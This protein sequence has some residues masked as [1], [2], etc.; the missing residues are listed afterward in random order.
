[1]KNQL[2]GKYLNVNFNNFRG[3]GLNVA[4]EESTNRSEE[5]NQF[6]KKTKKSLD[7]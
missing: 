1:M 2:K 7:G 6:Q 3:A 5:D 4:E